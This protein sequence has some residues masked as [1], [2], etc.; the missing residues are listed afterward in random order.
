[1]VAK[2]SPKYLYGMMTGAWYIITASLAAVLSGLL[3]NM[4]SIPD[5]LQNN[6]PAMM[7]IY[8]SAFFKMGMIAVVAAVIGF[9][10]SPFLKKLAGLDDAK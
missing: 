5:N 6:M 4:A 9:V 8:K 7:E 3:A 2:I 1:M 10:I